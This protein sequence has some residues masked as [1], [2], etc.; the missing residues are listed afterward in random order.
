MCIG[1][2]GVRHSAELSPCAAC[3]GLTVL[4]GSTLYG[5]GRAEGIGS[6]EDFAS[7][8]V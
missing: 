2:H 8:A 1:R 3:G 4:T 6:A 7:V 5:Q